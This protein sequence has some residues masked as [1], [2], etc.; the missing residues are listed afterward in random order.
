MKEFD[1]KK[2]LNELNENQYNNL[3]NCEYEDIR[4]HWKL[5]DNEKNQNPFLELK[6]KLKARFEPN[7]LI[8]S[9]SYVNIGFF[10]YKIN[11]EA[12]KPGLLDR[13]KIGNDFGIDLLIKRRYE[14][15]EN[16]IKK[17]NLII[18]RRQIFELRVGDKIVIYIS[19]RKYKKKSG[20]KK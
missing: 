1:L 13:S 16:E 7:F 8:E 18:E 9:I 4:P 19:L 3:R 12:K 2:Y 5:I 17:N 15:I 10:L 14:S 11:L 6:A 20:R